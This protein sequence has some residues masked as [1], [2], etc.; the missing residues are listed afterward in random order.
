MDNVYIR[1]ND[2]SYK[3]IN[4]L[5]YN[6]IVYSNLEKLNECYYLV[7]KYSDY[8]KISRRYEVCII[9]Y[10]GKRRIKYFVDEN[11]YLIIGFIIS[12]LFLKL[13][14]MTIFD[15]R[16]NTSSI[17]IKNMIL[18]SLNDNGI[19][20]GKKKKNF[21]EIK[22]IKEKILESHKNALEWIEIREKGCVY[23]VD[24]TPKVI[25]DYN[26]DNKESS[27]ISNT[28]GVI[29][30]IVVFKGTKMKEVNEYVKK[31]EVLISGN[32]FKDDKVVGK[33]NASGEVFAETWYYVNTSVSLNYNELIFDN[34]F[35]HLYIDIGGNKYTLIGKL[36]NEFVKTI[37]SKTISKPYLFFKIVNEKKV[38]YKKVE[39][40]I[41]KEKA[42]KIALEESINKIKSTLKDKEY[43]ISKNVLKK[44]VKYSRMNIEVFFKVYRN[45]GVT[46]KI[47]KIEKREE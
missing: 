46:S 22:L 33:V 35:N 8:K 36:D 24:V 26:N 15:I 6:K 47:E 45:I 39:K 16:V 17:E 29:K 10:Y 2:N 32:I 30:H 20:K 19:S 34:K 21:K 44:E 41:S 28:N 13:L 40:H 23:I 1:V 4:Y 42:Y 37:S 14:S 7:V 5:I 9:N 31:G 38:K 25:K 11:K 12:M 43:I 18:S 27:I 3:F